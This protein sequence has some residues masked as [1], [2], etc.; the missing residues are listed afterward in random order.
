MHFRCYL[1]LDPFE[2]RRRELMREKEITA[3]VERRLAEI[4]PQKVEEEMELR[5]EKMRQDI[6]LE[7]EEQAKRNSEELRLENQLLKEV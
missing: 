5:R 7:M 1:Q 3:E 4:L 2:V 6:R